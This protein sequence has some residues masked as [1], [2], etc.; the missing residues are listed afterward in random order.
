MSECT[1]WTKVSF[2]FSNLSQPTSWCKAVPFNPAHVQKLQWQWESSVLGS[3]AAGNFNIDEIHLST[4]SSNPVTA[5]TSLTISLVTDTDLAK[6]KCHANIDPL[7][8]PIGSGAQGDTCYLETKPTPTNAT[9]PVVNW[10]S[11]DE[12]VAKVDYRGR[13]TGV[14]YGEAIITAR[15]KMHQNI[16]IVTGKQ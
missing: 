4:A 16:A 7:K 1:T 3:Q 14:G 6:E 15:S 8:I 11:S 2:L 10:T 13:V 12:T 5:L 9:Y